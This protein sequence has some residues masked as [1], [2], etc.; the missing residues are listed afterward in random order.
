MR[1]TASPGFVMSYADTII[2]CS[3]SAIAARSA[4]S[5]V[6]RVGLAHAVAAMAAR[7]TDAIAR[8][9][10]DS[11]H[12]QCAPEGPKVWRILCISRTRTP[13]QSGAISRW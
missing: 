12:Q 4:G 11:V 10:L 5:S 2:R 1:A 6:S 8:P 7:V 9:A 13:T 3:V